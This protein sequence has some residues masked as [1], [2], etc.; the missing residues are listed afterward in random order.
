[1]T[2]MTAEQAGIVPQLQWVYN[3]LLYYLNSLYYSGLYL[4]NVY[5]V[6][7]LERDT[8]VNVSNALSNYFA[9]WT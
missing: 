2:P 7:Q 3:W 9:F 6:E 8:L 4:L 5:S 1:M